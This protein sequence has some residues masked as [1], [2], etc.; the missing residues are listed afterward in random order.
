MPVDHQRRRAVIAGIAVSGTIL[1]GGGTWLTIDGPHQPLSIQAA[2]IELDKLMVT[3]PT[4]N[5]DW[6]LAQMLTHCAQSVEYSMVGFPEHKS[7]VFKHSVGALAFGLFAAKGRMTHGLS[8]PI[9]G[10]PLLEAGGSVAQAGMRLQRAL[11][12]FDDFKGLLAPH[13]A[14]GYLSKPQ[15]EQAHVMHFYNHLTQLQEQ[16]A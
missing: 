11:H 10:A 1:L 4:L 3:S 15:Y 7:A 9:P 5:G 13:F 2:L 12:E 16:H 6:D 14:Y 8:E